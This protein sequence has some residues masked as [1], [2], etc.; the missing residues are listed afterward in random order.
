MVRIGII[1]CG[2]IAI[3]RHA[4]EYADNPNAEL[5]GFFDVRRESAQA[6]A[7]RY[8]GKVYGDWHE[9]AE[10]DEIDAVSIC[11]PNRMH[12]EMAVYCLEHGKHVLCE[13]P[14]AV[15]LED[16]EAMVEASRR[17]G[18][19]LFIGQNQRLAEAHVKAKKLIEEGVI[20]KVLSFQS[21]FCHAGP[22]EWA[23]SQG[24]NIWFF[25]KKFAAFGALFDLGIHKFD[26][27]S[28]MLGG[29]AY[30]DVM[31]TLDTLDKKKSDGTPIDV[32]D[33]AMCI[34]H[35]ENGIPGFIN[36]SWTHYGDE[37]NYTRFFGT[38]GMLRVF[39]DPNHPLILSIR[40]KSDHCFPVE[41]LQTN[42]NQFHTG[43]VDTFVEDIIE[44]RPATISGESVLRSMR[45]IFAAA[46]SSET[47]QL[48]H[49]ENN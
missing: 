33:N 48:V 38:K 42:D 40:G 24:K 17:S 37:T 12:A 9:L 32:D 43:I 7:D 6:L 20:G 30:S 19:I 10:S 2:M 46:K 11:A 13:K 8:G 34:V 26:V 4:P 41:K 39:D 22:E 21:G 27:V 14:M 25:D 35:T 44:G 49:I 3:K 5:K 16:C 45:A 28:D 18:K 31:A 47:G 1:G 29:V 15:S 23:A 36:A